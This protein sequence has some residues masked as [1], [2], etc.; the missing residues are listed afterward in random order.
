LRRFDQILSVDGVSFRG[1]TSADVVARLRGPAGSS[2]VLRVRRPGHTLEIPV[3]RAVIQTPTAEAVLIRPGVAYVRVWSFSRGAAAEVRRALEALGDP[4]DVRSIVLDL[5]GNPGGLVVEAEWMA[6]L[7]LGAGTVLARTRS[8]TGAGTFVATGAPV[9]RNASIVVLADRGSASG[10]EILT[11]GLRD[12]NRAVVVGE[13]TAGAFGGA[14]DFP[15]SEGGI[16]V[17]T[18]ALTGP[19]GEDIEGVG[20]TPD[21]AVAITADDMLRGDDAQLDA[22][23]SLVGA[24]WLIGDGRAVVSVIAA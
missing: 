23:L 21:H 3:T 1:G 14:R 8:S 15:L 4:R 11:V 10:A 9:Y 18:R 6:G 22:A 12:A 13:T 20:I 17:T 16:M 7:F 19:R 24:V 5:R 2:I